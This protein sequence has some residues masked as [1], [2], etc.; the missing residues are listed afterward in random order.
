M[1]NE[2]AKLNFF[3]LENQNFNGLDHDPSNSLFV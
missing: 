3:K 2:Y 1:K